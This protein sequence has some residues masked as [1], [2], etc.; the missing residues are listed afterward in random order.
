MNRSDFILLEQTGKTRDFRFSHVT[1]LSKLST[2][3]R[4]GWMKNENISDEHF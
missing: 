1:R 3:E 2:R 4:T